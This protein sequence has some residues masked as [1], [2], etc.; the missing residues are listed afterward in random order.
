MKKERKKEIQQGERRARSFACFG[1]RALAR[2]EIQRALQRERQRKRNPR[3][4]REREKEKR[5]RTEGE[6]KE[7]EGAQENAEGMLCV[8][9]G[10]ARLAHTRCWHL[11]PSE[12]SIGTFTWNLFGTLWTLDTE[13]SLGTSEPSL[14]TFFELFRRLTRNLNL[15]TFGAFTRNLCLEPRNPHLEPSE[16]S[17]GTFTWNF[18]NLHLEPRNPQLE[19]S[20]PLLGTFTWNSSDT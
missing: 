3:R 16:P 12:T 4:E 14:G 7:R 15:G 2:P 19:P 6:E 18:R 9:L 5:R 8:R 11:E 17:L 10:W 20:E 1:R 13:P